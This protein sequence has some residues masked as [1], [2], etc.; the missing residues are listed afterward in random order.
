[1]SVTVSEEF[2]FPQRKVSYFIHLFVRRFCPGIAFKVTKSAKTE[3]LHT[4]ILIHSSI[5]PF[6]HH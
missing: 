1:M 4:L 6:P 3:I 5:I 2:H